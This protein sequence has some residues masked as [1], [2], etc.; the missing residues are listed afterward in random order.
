VATAPRNGWNLRQVGP[1]NPSRTSLFDRLWAR[2]LP[3]VCADTLPP[4]GRRTRRASPPAM[5]HRDAR[6]SGSRA[7]ELCGGGGVWG[8]GGLGGGGGGGGLG[9]GGG[10]GLCDLAKQQH[11]KDPRGGIVR[12]NVVSLHE[13]MASDPTCLPLHSAYRY[14][15]PMFSILSFIVLFTGPTARTA[16]RFLTFQRLQCALMSGWA[17]VMQL[18]HDL[19]FYSLLRSASASTARRHHRS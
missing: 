13:G 7:A 3:A 10:G 14:H 19:L 16:A 9:G 5:L 8:G 18:P 12:A 2:E 11:K 4:R 17:A 6:R 15:T 1:A